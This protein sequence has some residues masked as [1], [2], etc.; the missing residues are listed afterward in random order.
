MKKLPGW[1]LLAGGIWLFI[2]DHGFIGAVLIAA[3]A[4]LLG[5]GSGE[6]SGWGY[7]NSWWGSGG[8]SDG[9]D[10]GAGGGD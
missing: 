1:G 9:G 3:C 5:R 2:S 4:L 10:I 7:D 8:D 6:N